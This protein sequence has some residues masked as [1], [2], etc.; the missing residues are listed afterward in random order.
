MENKPN[1]IDD[2]SKG[3]ILNPVSY[4]ASISRHLPEMKKNYT[5]QNAKAF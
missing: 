4:F 3:D 1:K 5:W 2:P